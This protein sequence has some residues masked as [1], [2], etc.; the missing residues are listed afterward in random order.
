MK[1]IGLIG[2]LSWQSSVDYYRVINEESAKRLGGIH[3]ARSIMY[4]VDLSEMLGHMEKGETDILADKLA[5]VG[6]TVERAGAEVLLLCTNT[7]HAVSGKLEEQLGIPFVHIA[8]ATAREIKRLGLKKV[9]LMGTPFTMG[10]AFYKGRL[11]ERHGIE[12]VV[13]DS[14]RWDEIFRV[15]KEELTFGVIKE[16]SRR[17]YLDVI[18]EL[19]AMG[20]EGVILGCTEIPMLIKQEHTDVP[21]FDTT[22]LHALAAVELA[23]E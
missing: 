21:V 5:E 14:E 13:P 7:M 9:G 4:S 12:V 10:E 17:F 18:E 23:D 19:V 22:T 20:A 2:G 3:N 1:T 8:D 16:Q 15:I 11:Q 6:T